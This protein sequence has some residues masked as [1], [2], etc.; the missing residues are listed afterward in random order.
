MELDQKLD[1]NDYLVALTL[2]T[3]IDT[4]QYGGCDNDSPFCVAAGGGRRY[5]R[6]YHHER[7]VWDQI[8]L[9]LCWGEFQDSAI[10]YL[11]IKV[12]ILCICC[13]AER[14]IIIFGHLKR[15]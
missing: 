2:N 4:D 9:Q 5:P 15:I 12:S 8:F 3:S 10:L 11:V 14:Q 1:Y 6:G 13:D 7:N